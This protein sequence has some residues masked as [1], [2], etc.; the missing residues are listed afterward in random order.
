MKEIRPGNLVK[1]K[2]PSIG[3][4]ANT[5]A[6]VLKKEAF[7]PLDFHDVTPDFLYTVQLLGTG[8]HEILGFSERTYRAYDLEL[9]C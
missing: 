1:I 2:R 6:L 8:S 9:I 7:K 3:V 4:P 5:H